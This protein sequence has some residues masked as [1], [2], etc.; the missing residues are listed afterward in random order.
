M[1]AEHTQGHQQD[2]RQQ[3]DTLYV[4]RTRVMRKAAIHAVTHWKPMTKSI[5]R[6]PSSRRMVAM[7]AM[8]GV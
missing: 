3:D 7:A 2:G 5:Q 6:V 8:Q 1:I 4:H